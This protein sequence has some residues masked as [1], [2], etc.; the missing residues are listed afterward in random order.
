[1]L[2]TLLRRWLSSKLRSTT[3]KRLR[4]GTRVSVK[5]RSSLERAV[6]RALGVHTLRSSYR[7]RVPEYHGVGRGWDSHRTPPSLPQRIILCNT[8]LHG[9]R[10][11]KSLQRRCWR[12]VF[13][14]NATLRVLRPMYSAD[15]Q[16][17]VQFRNLSFELISDLPQD[18]LML[19]IV[20]RPPFHQHLSHSGNR[21]IGKQPHINFLQLRLSP[22]L[23][24]Q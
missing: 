7:R 15:Y 1:M 4:F 5:D 22:L 12:S 18:F 2:L 23:P 17:I 21:S 16:R 9:H 8:T 10:T 13:A 11:S 3:R 20:N 24:I 19:D 6:Q 14:S